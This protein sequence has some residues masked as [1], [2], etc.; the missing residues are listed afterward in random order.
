MLACRSVY[1]K[2]CSFSNCCVCLLRQSLKKDYVVSN[3]L[4][5]NWTIR[6]KENLVLQA[7]LADSNLPLL[8]TAFSVSSS[9]EKSGSPPVSYHEAMTRHEE[10]EEP[11]HRERER[12]E[13]PE[14]SYPSQLVKQEMTEEETPMETQR[15]CEDEAHPAASPV[16][17]YRHYSGMEEDRPRSHSPVPPSPVSQPPPPPVSHSMPHVPTSLGL[18]PPLQLLH[19][20]HMRQGP[21]LEG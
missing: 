21:P 15:D 20:A 19:E 5:G 4:I 12:E 13:E 3:V 2:Y 8:N 9:V 11:S 1:P 6:L 16:S 17:H 10:D 7:A 14:D 18:P